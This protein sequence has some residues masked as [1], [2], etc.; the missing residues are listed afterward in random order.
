MVRMLSLSLVAGLALGLSAAPAAAKK[1]KPRKMTC[2]EFVALD[3]SD[4][5]A[6][7]AYLDGHGQGATAVPVAE[8]DVQRESG[9]IIEDCKTTPKET[10][11]Q[12]I[13]KHVPGGKKLIKPPKM[14]CEEFGALSSEEQP[15]AYYFASGYDHATNQVTE[16]AGEIDLDWPAFSG[17]RVKR[18]SF[19]CL[20]KAV[21]SP[22]S[23]LAKGKTST[24]MTRY[25]SEGARFLKRGQTLLRIAV[26]FVYT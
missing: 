9:A 23:V 5:S 10:L 18:A 20:P 13:V 3:V 14:T 16:D 11:A 24:S 15:L 17:G 26:H 6:V 22:P 1:V 21:S 7:L 12:K 19:I 4:Q 2:E 25:S 8:L